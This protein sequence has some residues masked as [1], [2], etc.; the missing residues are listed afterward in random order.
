MKL[1]LPL[2]I[3]YFCV[4]GCLNTDQKRQIDVPPRFVSNDTTDGKQFIAILKPDTEFKST[5][6]TKADLKL[7]DDLLNEAVNGFNKRQEKRRKDGKTFGSPIDLKKYKRQYIAHKNKEGTREV[8]I[9]CF[10]RSHDDTKW[11]TELVVVEDGGSCFFNL[12][13]DLTNK[14]YFEFSVNGL[15]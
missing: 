11:K 2:F 7:I 15:A 13:I 1:N 14:Q 5:E 4:I 12:K 10:C 6:L 9:N 3:L 8:W